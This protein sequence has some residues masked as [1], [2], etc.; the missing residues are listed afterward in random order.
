MYLRL[1]TANIDMNPDNPARIVHVLKVDG[2]SAKLRA[3]LWAINQHSL[4][5]EKMD[6]PF[7]YL[8]KIAQRHDAVVWGGR[9]VY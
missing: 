7:L 9:G 2:H 3:A 4:L 6:A 5:F 1:L 8:G